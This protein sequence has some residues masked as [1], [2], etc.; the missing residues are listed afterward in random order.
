MP[1]LRS[2]KNG[3]DAGEPCGESP[4]GIVATTDRDAVLK[5]D[6]DCCVLTT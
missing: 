2:A 6:A 5:L 1:K 3:V 4:V